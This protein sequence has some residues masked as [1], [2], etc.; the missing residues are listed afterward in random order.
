MIKT[1]CDRILEEDKRMIITRK[2]SIHPEMITIKNNPIMSQ[3][4]GVI[5]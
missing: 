3:T 2:I 4:T 1:V 5:I